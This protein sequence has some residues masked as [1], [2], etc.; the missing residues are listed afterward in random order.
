MQRARRSLHPSGSARASTNFCAR[1]FLVAFQ[2]ALNVTFSFL[3]NL[4]YIRNVHSRSTGWPDNFERL[5]LE[6]GN[7][8]SKGRPDW[9]C[10]HRIVPF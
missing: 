6:G 2:A 3:Q 8:D 1:D 9:R 5:S 7:S 4:C 10:E